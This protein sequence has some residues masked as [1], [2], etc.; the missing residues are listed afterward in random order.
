[1]N[2]D[3]DGWMKQLRRLELAKQCLRNVLCTDPQCLPRTERME[4]DRAIAAIERAR[5]LYQRFLPKELTQ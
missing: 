4:I 5:E 1:M 2:D 3:R